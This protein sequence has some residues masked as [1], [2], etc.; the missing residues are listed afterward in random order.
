MA[1]KRKLGLR[2]TSLMDS[3]CLELAAF[4]EERG[5]RVVNEGDLIYRFMFIHSHLHI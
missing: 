3:E 4:S 5:I 2:K 1:W